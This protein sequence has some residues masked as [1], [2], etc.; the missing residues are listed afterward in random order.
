MSEPFVLRATKP[1]IN[2][3]LFSVHPH[4]TPLYEIRYQPVLAVFLDGDPLSL[5]QVKT[6]IQVSSKEFK[7]FRTGEW[8]SAF[9]DTELWLCSFLPPTAGVNKVTGSRIGTYGGENVSQ[10]DN[11]RPYYKPFLFADIENPPVDRFVVLMAQC[12]SEGGKDPQY[13]SIPDTGPYNQ[14]TVT[15]WAKE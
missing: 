7:D 9:V 8:G 2:K 1:L 5:I 11:R 3:L 10:K 13:L 15:C 6:Q 14:M 12:S 4:D